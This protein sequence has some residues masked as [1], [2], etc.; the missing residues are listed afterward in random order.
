M[1]KYVWVI[2]N[3]TLNEVLRCYGPH[4]WN[5]LPVT[6]EDAK[7]EGALTTGWR[8]ERVRALSVTELQ[9]RTYFEKH[10]G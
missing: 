10:L 3:D 1:V 8:V 4:E 6:S 7:R 9:W 5:S 2:N